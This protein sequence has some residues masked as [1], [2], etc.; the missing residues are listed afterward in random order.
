VPGVEVVA[1]T[2]APVLQCD[3]VAGDGCDE[4]VARDA[5]ASNRLINIGRPDHVGDRVVAVRVAGDRRRDRGVDKVAGVRIDV[6]N[7][8]QAD[9]GGGTKH[10][11]D[12]GARRYPE[13]AV[14]ERKLI[15]LCAVDPNDVRVCCGAP[16]ADLGCAKIVD[17]QAIRTVA[18]HVD[19]CI[20]RR[21]G[22]LRRHQVIDRDVLMETRGLVDVLRDQDC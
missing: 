11:Q 7:R 2:D 13:I 21:S 3:R 10:V 9:R 16:A 12:I 5:G 4:R 19:R 15:D 18:G 14:V 22:G 8:G 20:G 1:L 6:R 17:D